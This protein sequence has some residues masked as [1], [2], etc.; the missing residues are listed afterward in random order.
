MDNPGFNSS[1]FIANTYATWNKISCFH[2]VKEERFRVFLG[3]RI[4]PF[5]NLTQMK[6][7]FSLARECGNIRR[8]LLKST[9]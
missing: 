2:L 1:R 7:V 9:V 3:K 6:Q 8:V 4:K 5:R